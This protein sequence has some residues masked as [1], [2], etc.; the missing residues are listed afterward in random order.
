MAQTNK[1]STLT[2]QQKWKIIH[3]YE[4]VKSIAATA[5]E[6]GHSKAAVSRW[7]QRFERFGNVDS[8]PKRG[9]KPIFTG[10]LAQEALELLKGGQY[11]G[12]RGVAS[13]MKASG[14]LHKQVD[15]NTIIRH[16]RK[17]ANRRGD[18]LL[19]RRGY[20]KKGLTEATKIKRLSFAK[21]NQFFQWDHVMFT[22]RKKF[23]LKYPGSAVTNSKWYQKAE[24]MGKEDGVF[25]PNNPNNFNIYA[26]ITKF[27]TTMVHEVA[28]STA[29][30]HTHVNKKGQAA[31]NITSEQYKDVLLQT[32]LPGGCKLFNKA[33]WYLQ[34]DNDPTHRIAREIVDEWNKT[35]DTDVQVL[36]GWPPNSPDLS[37][38]ENFWSYI[39][40][41]VYG[42][43]CKDIK[44]FKECV[45]KEIGAWNLQRENYMKNLYASMPTRM[46]LVLQNKG[47]KTGY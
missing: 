26:G 27:G 39:E 12:A 17:A 7:V 35:N 21:S 41:K 32:L 9:R 16:A 43:G 46:A 3:V 1:T 47:G 34:Q 24:S 45:K 44:E 25:Q 37:L 2:I 11:S 15:K 33:R 28:G 38:I 36:F 8:K 10:E 18:T 29:Y 6:V 13:H 31:K 14:M 4:Q 22:D 19:V 23:F 5:R 30:K 42:V 40:N 20:P